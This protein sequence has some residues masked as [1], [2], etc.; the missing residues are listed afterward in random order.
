MPKPTGSVLDAKL[1]A[2]LGWF[3]LALGFTDIVFARHA[4]TRSIWA[5]MGAFAL[6]ALA[7]AAALETAKSARLAR[8]GSARFARP[9][10][11]R[12]ELMGADEAGS[13]AEYVEG[14]PAGP[15]A[16]TLH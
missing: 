13:T 10:G 14:E 12:P 15:A 16:R 4:G 9:D 11:D 5:R 7:G 1:V 8:Q 3:G 2:C 6:A